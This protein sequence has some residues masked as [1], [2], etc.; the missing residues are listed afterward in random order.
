MDYMIVT[1][2]DGSHHATNGMVGMSVLPELAQPNSSLSQARLFKRCAMKNAM[3]PAVHMTTWLV[4]EID[5]VRCY[6]KQDGVQLHI[7][8]TRQDLYP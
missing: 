3:T 1:D 7:V 6:V 4:G 2:P 5:G 8:M